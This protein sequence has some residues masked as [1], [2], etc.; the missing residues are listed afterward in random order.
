MTDYDI[1]KSCVQLAL[2]IGQH[3]PGY[4]D[5]YFGPPKWQAQAMRELRPLNVLARECEDLTAALDENSTMDPQRRDYLAKEVRSMQTSLA[6]LQGEAPALLKEAEAIYDI[7]PTW[8]D[9][10]VFERCHQLIDDVLPSGNS[11]VERM[12][13]AKANARVTLTRDS[14]LVATII[15]E[16]RRRTQAR[17]GLP[18]GESLSVLLVSDKNWSAYNWYLGELNS[19]IEINVDRPLHIMRLLHL[20]AHEGYPGHH[21]ELST[22]ETCLARNRGW[23]EHTVTSLDSAACVVAEGIAT[24]ALQA[25]MSKDELTD[26]CNTELFPRF[27]L[28]HL[29]AERELALEVARL[30][31]AG[32]RDNAAFLLH[33]ERSAP[34]KVLAYVVRYGLACE[35]EAEQIVRFIS[36]CR[37]YIFTYRHGGELLAQLFVHKPGPVHWFARLLREPVTP[38]QIR[39]WIAA[40]AEKSTLP[41]DSQR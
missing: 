23:V 1:A 40:L 14:E 7:T 6:I 41:I 21:T 11:L 9:E 29:E 39:S 13:A 19:R 10:S 8:I 25:L 16:L 37:S 2:A 28:A 38:S 35:R 26:W 20:M 31:L 27:G 5:A 34:S 18:P 22:K 33:I 4:I 36:S 30:Q 24:Q 32:V 3:R 15:G 17:F 12:A